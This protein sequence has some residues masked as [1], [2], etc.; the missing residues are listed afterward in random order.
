VHADLSYVP[1]AHLVWLS[2]LGLTFEDE[3]RVFVH[4]WIE[5]GVPLAQQSRHDMQWKL[6]PENHPGGWRGKHVV[7]GH[8][9]FDAGPLRFPYR[10]NLDTRAFRTGRLVVGV[11]DDD[12]PGGP[13]ELLEVIGAPRHSALAVATSPS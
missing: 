13:V 2:E 4:A 12:V 6:Y 8:D 7:H 1:S 9:F 3:H 5:D 10:T 11:F